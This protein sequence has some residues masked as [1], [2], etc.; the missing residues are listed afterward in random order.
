M[1]RK[2][3]TCVLPAL[4]VGVRTCLLSDAYVTHMIKQLEE[5]FMLECLE[6]GKY[7][8]IPA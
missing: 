7:Y 2:G 8:F 5:V 1:S 3:D 4:M 6:S